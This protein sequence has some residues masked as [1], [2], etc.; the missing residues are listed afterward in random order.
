VRPDDAADQ[1][2]AELS[3]GPEPVTDDEGK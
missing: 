1:L 3:D 2:L